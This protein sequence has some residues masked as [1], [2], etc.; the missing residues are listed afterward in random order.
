MGKK[1]ISWIKRRPYKTFFLILIL[2]Y[3]LLVFIVALPLLR[4]AF[5]PFR[6]LGGEKSY[7]ILFQNNYELRPTGG[8]ISAFGILTVRNGFPVS[9]NFE[10]VYGSV[11]DHPSIEPPPPLGSLLAHP[12][13]HGHTFRD[14]NFYPD[15]PRSTEELEI[16]L[17]KTRPFQK[18]DGVFAVDMKFVE[19]WLAKVGS[20]EVDG[21]VFDSTHLLEQMEEVVANID[22]HDLQDL[23]KRKSGI[24]QL[25]R[26]LAKK[27][28][29]P[30]NVPKF[31][32]TVVDGFREK[33]ILA[34]FKD[35]SIQALVREKNWGGI[36]EPQTAEDFL[37]IVDANYGGGKS[38]RYVK[39][40]VYYFIDLE[41]GRSEL[42]VRYDHSGEYNIPLSTDYRGYVRA[43]LPADHSVKSA[44]LQGHEGN[45]FYA[46][47]TF[48]TPIRANS[49]VHFDFDFPPSTLDELTYRLNLWKQPGTDGDFYHVAVRVPTGMQLT[50]DQFEVTENIATFR[51]FLN[52]DTKLIF[53]LEKDPY[54]PR[55]I[56]QN[57]KELNLL[58]IEWNEP[59]GPSSLH[60]EEW[61][62]SDSD[63]QNPQSDRIIIDSVKFEGTKLII[64]TRGMTLQPEERYVLDISGVSDFHGNSTGKRTYTFFQRLE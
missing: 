50:S 59:L 29:L 56:S 10:D 57:L 51:G 28:L 11:D 44:E 20:V 31:L 15:F 58:E 62:I 45:L 37:A 34:Y 13:Y 18:I 14:A 4:F 54:P 40:S 9:L 8:F 35:E 43:Y 49:T 41:S 33:H 39:R 7:L 27:S 22:L 61:K 63:I 64:K 26:Q 1:I 6:L 3:F 47:K 42:D 16:F 5:F 48:T 36:L 55:V 2:S 32:K 17:H 25:T 46:G 30:W 21:T 19:N 24:K 52:D 23:E 12:S 53:T 38:N 60:S